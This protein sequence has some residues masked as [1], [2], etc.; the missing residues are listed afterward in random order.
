MLTAIDYSQIACQLAQRSL[1]P[2]REGKAVDI[3]HANKQFVVFAPFD[4]CRLHANIASRVFELRRIKTREVGERVVPLDD[5]W[6]VLGG[7]HFEI[8][9]DSQELKLFSDST[10]YGCIDLLYLRTELLA[11]ELFRAYQIDVPA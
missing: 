9:D 11:T 6:Q 10:A 1:N 3:C 7:C 5:S 8:D 4:F 2:K